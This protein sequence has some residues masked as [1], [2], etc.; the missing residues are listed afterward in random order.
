MRTL[1]ARERT[2]TANWRLAALLAFIAGMADVSGYLSLGQFTAHMSGVVATL[3]LRA[4]LS[5]L[6]L[7]A[8]VLSALLSFTFGSAMTALLVNWVRQHHGES[9]YALPLL[10]E[11]AALFSAALLAHRLPPWAVIGLLAFSMGLQNATI[12]KLSNKEIRTTHV[13]GMV[14]DIGIELGRALYRNGSAATS[15]PINMR[16]RHL[17]LLLL[18]VGLFFAG[19][20]LAASLFHLTGLWLL[21][22]LSLLLILIAIFPIT[23]DLRHTYVPPQ[24]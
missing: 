5:S 19:G 11:S 3:A 2:E 16:P 18:L 10:L 24:A 15:T 21:A 17:A 6:T 1:A 13:T 4:P 22:S 14:T 23:R 12:S 20:C 7:L 8:P 9:E